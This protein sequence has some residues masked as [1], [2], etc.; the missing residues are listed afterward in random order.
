MQQLTIE[1]QVAPTSHSQVISILRMI[2]FGRQNNGP[3]RPWEDAEET[4]AASSER[5]PSPDDYGLHCRAQH[6]H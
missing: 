1:F 5:C 2:G 6:N 3:M 4:K